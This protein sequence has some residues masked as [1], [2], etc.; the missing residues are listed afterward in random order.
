MK[1]QKTEYVGIRIETDVAAWLKGEA[2]NKRETVSN[3]VRR[4]LYEAYNEHHELL[5]ERG[6]NYETGKREK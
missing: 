6:N 3:V 4:H 2:D 5:K 1:K